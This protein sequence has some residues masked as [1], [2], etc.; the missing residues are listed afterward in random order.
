MWSGEGA[1]AVGGV[2]AVGAELEEHK[3]GGEPGGSGDSGIDPEEGRNGDG[4]DWMEAAA[5][6][7]E[8]QR[9]PEGGK[10]S[11]GGR[12]RMEAVVFGEEG[13]HEPEGGRDSGG[14]DPEGGTETS[15]GRK[16]DA[17]GGVGVE[18]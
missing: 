8:G 4:Q 1:Y 17:A 2:A 6:G 16:K 15:D 5:S 13:R 9:E 3:H 10:D 18:R 14:I 11:G 7:E 12:D